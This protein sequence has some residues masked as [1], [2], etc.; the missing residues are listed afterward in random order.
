MLKSFTVS[1]AV[2]EPHGRDA[3]TDLVCDFTVDA[4]DAD[5]AVETARR[6]LDIPSNGAEVSATREGVIVTD[7]LNT[8]PAP[9]RRRFYVFGAY[10]SLSAPIRRRTALT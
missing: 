1:V 2:S 8:T 6:C 7:K 5:E 3:L 10:H 9:K 4:R